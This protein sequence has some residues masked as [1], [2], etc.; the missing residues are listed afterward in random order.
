VKRVIDVIVAV[1]VLALTWPL[2]FAITCLIRLDSPGPAIFRQK[3]VGFRGK[4]F[5][6]L[7]F[8]TMK[9]GSGTPSDYVSPNDPRVTRLGKFLRAT[10]L[11]ELPQMINVLRGEMSI[12]GPRPLGVDNDADREENI[13]H[14]RH[15]RMVKPG[16]TGLQQICGKS[17]F[18]AKDM[19]KS[20]CRALELDLL[21]VKRQSLALD[22]YLLWRTVPLVFQR[23]GI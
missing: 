23:K 22:L 13:P 15:R 3:R 2:W 18:L 16:L 6:I 7:K 1:F 10:Y 17:Q 4:I 14:Y 9:D 11:D 12:V 20:L 8:R 19:K 21:Y 5:T